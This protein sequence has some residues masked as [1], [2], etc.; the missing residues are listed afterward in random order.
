VLNVSK[1]V[2]TLDRPW[3]GSTTIPFEYL[4]LAT[5]TRLPAPGSV[6]A[7]DKPSGVELFRAYQQ[8]I[9]AADSIAI[10]GGGAVG[11]QMAT[12]IKEY[13]PSKEVTLIHSRE[14]VMPRFHPR[15]HDIISKR[16]DQLGVNLVTGS[17]VVVPPEGYPLDGRI[18]KVELKDGRTIT[19]QLVILATGQLPNN[20][21]I[22]SLDGDIVNPVNGFVRVRPT[23]QFKDARYDHL[24]ALGDIA[25]SGAHKAAKPGMVQA[26]VVTKNIVAMIE[27]RQPEAVIEVG[28]AAIHMSLGMVSSARHTN[29]REGLPAD[30]RC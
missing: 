20:G 8:G 22:S 28:P 15:L 4:V 24:F 17:R 30:Q 25:D 26:D 27:G 7:E 2:V 10:V 14:H 3:Q 18:T 12:D 16:F 29:P 11:V 19:T 9:L 1:N 23:L 21:L 6:V 13:Y 5:G